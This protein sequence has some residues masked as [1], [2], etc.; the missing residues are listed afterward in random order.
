MVLQ[1]VQGGVR[2][3]SDLPKTN[4]LFELLGAVFC[5]LMLP[6]ALLRSFGV[7]NI[8]FVSIVSVFA[9]FTIVNAVQYDNRLFWITTALSLGILFF[10]TYC[11]TRR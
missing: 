7:S 10:T 4:W 11:V 1:D 9:G 8:F 3:K 6:V 2:V 5:I